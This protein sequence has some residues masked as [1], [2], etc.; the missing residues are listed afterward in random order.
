MFHLGALSSSG[1]PTNTSLWATHFLV[2]ETLASIQRHRTERRSPAPYLPP[3]LTPRSPEAR[4]NVEAGFDGTLWLE[5]ESAPLSTADR[6]RRAV[7]LLRTLRRA[8]PTR[9]AFT[10][11][12]ALSRLLLRAHLS[13]RIRASFGRDRPV[14]AALLGKMQVRFS[15]P[16]ARKRWIVSPLLN[17]HTK[18][19]TRLSVEISRKSLGPTHRFAPSMRLRCR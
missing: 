4:G 7:R 10:K 5:G 18:P 9:K 2:E 13:S 19:Q 11:N 12:K 16:F 3:P 15:P 8:L 6:E 1:L 17:T 14:C